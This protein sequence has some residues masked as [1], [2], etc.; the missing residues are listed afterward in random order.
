MENERVEREKVKNV[1]SYFALRKHEMLSLDD[2]IKCRN[3]SYS[4]K[5]TVTMKGNKHI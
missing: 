1:M 2:R 5:I 3:L 4:L